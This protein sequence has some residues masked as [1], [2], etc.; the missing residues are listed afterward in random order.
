V[1]PPIRSLR[2]RH[3]QPSPRRDYDTRVNRL[4]PETH[5]TLAAIGALWVSFAANASARQPPTPEF[6]LNS[7]DAVAA[8]GLASLSP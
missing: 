3:V 4:T 7:S 5:R 8:A 6:P 2:L 1:L